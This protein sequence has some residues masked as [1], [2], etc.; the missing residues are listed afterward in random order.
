MNGGQTKGR[1]PTL[2]GLSMA[3]LPATSMVVFLSLTRLPEDSSV[4]S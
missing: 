4:A 2:P 1:L 3:Q